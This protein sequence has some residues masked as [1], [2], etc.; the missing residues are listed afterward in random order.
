MTFSAN[1]LPES[2]PIL[3][4]LLKLFSSDEFLPLAFEICSNELT[5]KLLFN[6]IFNSNHEIIH[7]HLCQFFKRLLPLTDVE[8]KENE[9]NINRFSLIG[10]KQFKELLK[11]LNI[12]K[13]DSFN[14]PSNAY[15]DS[16]IA[17]LITRFPTFRKTFSD[18][19]DFD[20]INSNFE[21]LR[22][23]SSAFVNIVALGKSSSA[24]S[25]NEI[26]SALKISHLIVISALNGDD[27]TEIDYVLNL[28]NEL[29]EIQTL[30]NHIQNSP[31]SIKVNKK[32][33][34]TLLKVC[35]QFLKFEISHHFIKSNIKDL[36]LKI[37]ILVDKHEII[38]DESLNDLIQIINIVEAN[39]IKFSSE[40]IESFLITVS[41]H[42]LN[43]FKLMIISNELLNLID[44]TP[45]LCLSLL[46][47]VYGSKLFKDVMMISNDVKFGVSKF[48]NNLFYKSPQTLCQLVHINSLV[49]S[50]GG[51]LHES[52]TLILDIFNLF[53][54]VTRS[55]LA[56]ITRIWQP[57]SNIP[58]PNNNNRTMDVINNLDS[59]KVFQTCLNFPN[60]LSFDNSISVVDDTI[61]DKSQIY[62][63]RFLM[64]LLASVFRDETITDF[65]YLDLVRCSIINIPIMG[66]SSRRVD[67][68][69]ISLHL[70]TFIYDSLE[71]SFITIIII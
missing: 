10:Y 42:G 66:L 24:V 14:L 36:L 58:F 50:Y 17:L 57:P 12:Q 4:E 64:S 7:Y 39:G 43:N 59:A 49:N 70:L 25:D 28:Y 67:M 15:Q 63:P 60:R 69:K 65:E 2:S 3:I 37:L 41:Q 6:V 13:L 52:D 11:P 1:N 47:L 18:Y 34:R 19:V 61:K 9:E 23:S 8:I 71:V 32:F 26:K 45:Q 46:Q 22:R 33:T 5:L 40:D 53:E 56:S 51:S 35:R 30:I 29:S 16:L 20:H 27:K 21:V 48:V 55:S 62:D 44:L 54:R 38:D 31:Y 68:R